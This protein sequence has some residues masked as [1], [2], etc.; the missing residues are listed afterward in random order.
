MSRLFRISFL[1]LLTLVFAVLWTTGCHSNQNQ[2]AANAN[3]AAQPQ[4][5]QSGPDPASANLAP[6]ASG[7][8]GSDYASSDNNQDTADESEYGIQPAEYASDPPPPLP[9]YDQ[10]PDPGDGY[11]WTPGYWDYASAGFYWVPGAWV[12]APYEGALWTPGYWA[13]TNNRYAYFPGYWGTYIGFYG[14]VN[15]GFGYTGRGY[16]GGYWNN[17]QFY[18][19]RSVNNINVN[20]V[21]N[22]YNYRV[23]NYTSNRVSYNGG[24]GGLQMRPQMAELAALR[25]PRAAPMTT[26]IQLRTQAMANH[27]DFA[28]VNHGRPT[29]PV[30]T[31]PVAAERGVH[32]AA[33]PVRNLPAAARPAPET[34]RGGASPANPQQNRMQAQQEPS[35]TQ[36]ERQEARPNQP[37]K[38]G[39]EPMNRQSQSPAAAHTAEP[40]RREA[41]PTQPSR[42]AAKPE[43]PRPE[44]SR[45]AAKPEQ[46]Q[47]APQARPEAKPQEARPKTE[48]PAQH[49]AKQNSR[50]EQRK[51]SPEHKDEPPH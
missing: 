31:K 13:Y 9:D 33:V 37:P 47:P 46:K 5:D 20:V 2:N 19:N 15:Y 17:G 12:Q 27:A 29:Q 43:Q 11:I 16:Q 23:V 7:G 10:P 40:A 22:V 14:G 6:V 24:R 28:Q 21:R 25:E 34:A 51:P 36:P 50:D 4:Q 39:A 45:P 26:Q 35:R 41:T 3:Q 18:Y 48:A 38:N 8:T 32:P 1:P 30:F 49:E 44:T 42:S